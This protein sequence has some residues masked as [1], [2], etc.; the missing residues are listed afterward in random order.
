MKKLFLLALVGAFSFMAS[1]VSAQITVT[2]TNNSTCDYHVKVN[3]V[4]T[5]RCT[6]NGAGPTRNVLAGTTV[7]LTVPNVTPVGPMHVPCFGVNE[8]ATTCLP[9]LVGD[10]CSPFAASIAGY[11]SCGGTGSTVTYGGTP[12]APTLTIN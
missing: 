10:P 2:I 11:C 5:T 1:A 4:P 3:H 12:T 9:I 7:V 8:I 6:P